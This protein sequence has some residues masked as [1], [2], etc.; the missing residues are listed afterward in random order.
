VRSRW[1]YGVAAV[2]I[3]A[4]VLLG[5]DAWISS[6][7]R[8]SAPPGE[9]AA[10]S[11]AP[12]ATAG[13]SA[14][15]NAGG[16]PAPSVPAP[17]AEA[18]SAMPAAASDAGAPFDAGAARLMLRRAAAVKDWA[19]ATTAFFALADHDPD[20]F[21]DPTLV[22]AA[23]DMAAISGAAGGEEADRIFDALAR[24]LGSGGP[25]ILYEIVR[26]R[27]GSKSATRA[28]DLLR[29]EAVLARATAELRITIALRDAPCEDKSALL[30]RAVAEGDARTLLVMQT[31]GAACLG[32]N[33]ALYDAQRALRIRLQGLAP[34]P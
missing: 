22:V 24:R 18:R 5:A 32:R 30:D 19:R 33:Q 20:S 25:D 29:E 10:A 28:H 8:A 4:G 21:H 14:A 13:A 17:P 6:Q 15:A 34:R 12:A 26:T 7:R 2:V 27:G 9:A 3:V 1:Y 31:V 23:R 11:A 16:T